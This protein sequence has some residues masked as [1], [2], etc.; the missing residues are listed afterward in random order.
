MGLV[1][2]LAFSPKGGSLTGLT[3]NPAETNLVYEELHSSVLFF[4]CLS[5]SGGGCAYD[6]ESSS[7]KSRESTAGKWEGKG[8]AQLAL[9]MLLRIP[10]VLTMDHQTRSSGLSITLSGDPSEL[11]GHFLSTLVLML[12]S[13]WL[14]RC[15]CFVSQC[16]L[17]W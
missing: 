2:R 1:E 9:E 3:L 14:W 7:L 12:E 16:V 4:S 13:F 11:P 5:L 15:A 17:F 6:D 8:I 10:E